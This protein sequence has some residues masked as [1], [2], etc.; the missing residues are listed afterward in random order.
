MKITSSKIYGY[1]TIKLS[2]SEIKKEN[3][4]ILDS[5]INLCENTLI[6]YPSLRVF[7]SSDIE[8]EI[9]Y[10]NNTKLIEKLLKIW[11]TKEVYKAS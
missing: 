10:N 5:L 1:M 6:F 8:L 2:K 9:K 7:S 3:P 11:N 4:N